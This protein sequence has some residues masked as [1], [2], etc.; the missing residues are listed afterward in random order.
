MQHQPKDNITLCLHVTHAL[1][2]VR[3][4]FLSSIGYAVTLVSLLLV[5]TKFSNF[6]DLILVI[7]QSQ[8]VTPTSCC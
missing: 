6:H 2:Y 1:L 8:V 4:A 3:L 5:G 7:L